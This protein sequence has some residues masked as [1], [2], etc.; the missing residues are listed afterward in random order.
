MA[1]RI[2]WGLLLLL[3]AFG[4]LR[5]LIS[6]LYARAV[7]LAI[8]SQQQ[9]RSSKRRMKRAKWRED[10]VREAEHLLRRSEDEIEQRRRFQ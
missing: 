7:R 1:E 2:L 6:R 8:L 5:L 4:L 3:C 9:T 10:I